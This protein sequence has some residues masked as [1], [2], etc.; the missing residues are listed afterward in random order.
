MSNELVHKPREANLVLGP[1][2]VNRDDKQG[3]D[4]AH[5]LDFL[6]VRF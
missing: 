6:T 1:G 5:V 4:D 3:A 2:D